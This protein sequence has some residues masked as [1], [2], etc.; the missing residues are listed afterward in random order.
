[1]NIPDTGKLYE[2]NS[3]I[4]FNIGGLLAVFL[5][6]GTRYHSFL[7]VRLL[8]VILKYQKFKN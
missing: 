6:Q 2:I 4:S 1:M 7:H 5:S 3:G 8:S